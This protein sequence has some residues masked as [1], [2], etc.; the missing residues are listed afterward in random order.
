MVIDYN[1]RY[2]IL[3]HDFYEANGGLKDIKRTSDNFGE[4]IDHYEDCR[5]LYD[6]VCLYDGS[7]GKVLKSY[8]KDVRM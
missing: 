4:A 2:W 8:E 6:Y 3:A 1:H 7:P 5:G